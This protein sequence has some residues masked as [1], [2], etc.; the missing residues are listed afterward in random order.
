M[1]TTKEAVRMQYL[2]V[3]FFQMGDESREV[4][5]IFDEHGEQ[6]AFGYMLQWDTEP[7]N[8]QFKEWQDK[9]EW[10]NL[11]TNI[12]HLSGNV[13]YVASYN[14]R[15]GYAGLTKVRTIIS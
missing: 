4:L 14:F 7:E 8:D 15:L 6:A 12:P 5:A 11:D 13:N 3:V 2:N 10:G 9:P 1:S